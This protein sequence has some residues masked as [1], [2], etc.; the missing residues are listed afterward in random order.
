V[1]GRIKAF[2]RAEARPYPLKKCLSGASPM[3]IRIIRPNEDKE[4]LLNVDHISKIEVEYVVPGNGNE[5]WHTSVKDG[6][7]NPAAK[8]WYKVYVAGEV[9]QVLG[10]SS[11]RVKDVIESIYNAA[12]KG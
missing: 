9:L 3:F 5:Y 10:D 8:R 12:L 11:D 2:G 7:Q 1:R 6:M 4:L